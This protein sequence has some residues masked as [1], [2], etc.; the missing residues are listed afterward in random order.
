MGGR[1]FKKFKNIPTRSAHTGQMFQS[2]L[3]AR[4]EPVLLALQNVDAI[5]NLRYQVPFD[6]TIYGTQ[7]VEALLQAIEDAPV[8][9]ALFARHVQ[10]IRRSRLKVGKYVADFV[11]DME[12]RTVVE[13]TKGY[14]TPVYALKKKLMVVTQN[15]EIIE[16]NRGG[17]QQRARGAG[18]RG[19]G[20]GSRLKGG[21]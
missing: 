14:V 1:G 15:V 6:L 20:T 13:D 9:A 5:K 7:A 2:R 21:R 11:Y 16:P 4:R 3:E 10:D 8:V 17:V 12:G 18:V 19:E